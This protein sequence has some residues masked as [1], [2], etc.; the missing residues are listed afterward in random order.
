[1]TDPL[2]ERIEH[3]V[4]GNPGVHFR[5]LGRVVGVESSGQ[6]RHHLDRLLRDKRI[7]ETQEGRFKR[8]F[9][10]QYNA[11]LIPHIL[12]LC[13]PVPNAIVSALQAEGP[14]ARTDLRRRLG[15]ADS[16]LGYHLKRLLAHGDVQRRGGLYHS[17]VKVPLPSISWAPA[18]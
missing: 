17:A 1:M 9:S 7:L 6:L 2:H 3:A 5:A 10:A 15:V 13:R 12:V 16:T 4:R 14:M 18:R 8:Y 11:D